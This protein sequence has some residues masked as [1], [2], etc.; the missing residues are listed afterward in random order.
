MAT[1][2]PAQIK[3]AMKK[4]ATEKV[5][6][7]YIKLEE[8][9]ASLETA[10]YTPG[11]RSAAAKKEEKKIRSNLTLENIKEALPGALKYVDK[12]PTNFNLSA[13]KEAE[14]SNSVPKVLYGRSFLRSAMLPM[15]QV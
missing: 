2:T 9:L 14:R 5:V 10:E 4:L 15:T 3:A 1:T 6:Q 8:A 7:T 13:N 11:E 12:Q